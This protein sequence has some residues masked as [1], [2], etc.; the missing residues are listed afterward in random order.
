MS[1]RRGT[2]VPSLLQIQGR[3][4]LL[5]ILTSQWPTAAQGWVLRTCYR[6]TVLSSR[7]GILNH[8]QTCTSE[9]PNQEQWDASTDW[10]RLV[11]LLLPLGASTPTASI[12]SQRREFH[13][14]RRH[15]YRSAPVLHHVAAHWL[16]TIV[17][18]KVFGTHKIL[19]KPH[20]LSQHMN[21]GSCD[22]SVEFPFAHEAE[23]TPHAIG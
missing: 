4:S 13:C 19:L 23:I 20:L 18:G 7:Q 12:S 17:T 10:A 3:N 22:R 14:L 15:N 8:R 6:A 1:L 5:H 21:L 9:S 16:H 2:P 11:F